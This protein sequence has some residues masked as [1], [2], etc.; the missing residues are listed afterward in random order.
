MPSAVVRRRELAQR[1]H[2]GLAGCP[3]V[4]CPHEP[5]WARSNWQSYCLML[6]PAIDRDAVMTRLNSARIATRPGIAN[7]HAEPAYAGGGWRAAGELCRSEAAQ[8]HGL[9]LPIFEG[10]T[11]TDQTR[12]ID[13]VRRALP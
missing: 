5:D 11:D 6:D 3:G 12:I 2:D 7:A 9:M 1:Y 4:T 8:A 13:G 10:L